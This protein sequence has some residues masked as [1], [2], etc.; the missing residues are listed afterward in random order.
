MNKSPSTHNHNKNQAESTVA[1]T[2]TAEQRPAT[3]Y[4]ESVRITT[5]RLYNA[6]VK[7]HEQQWGD[8]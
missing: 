6:L 5:E 8:Q 4:V 2:P 1:P 3:P 7:I